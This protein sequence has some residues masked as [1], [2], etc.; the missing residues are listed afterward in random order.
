MSII[1]QVTLLGEMTRYLILDPEI[2]HAKYFRK[3]VIL[4]IQSPQVIN[5]IMVGRYIIMHAYTT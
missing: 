2:P 4:Q 5:I 3:T 1:V